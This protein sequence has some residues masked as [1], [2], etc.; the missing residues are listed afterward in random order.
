MAAWETYFDRFNH[1][2]MNLNL[3]P[4]GWLNFCLENKSKEGNK[5]IALGK[6]LI[7]NVNKLW[8]IF[9]TL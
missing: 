2:L 5:C 3:E 6:Q 4:R 7:S 8:T 1:S 9:K